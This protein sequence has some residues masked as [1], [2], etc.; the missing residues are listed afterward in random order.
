MEKKNIT[1]NPGKFRIFLDPDFDADLI[2][3]FVTI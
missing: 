2:A 3:Y 1:E